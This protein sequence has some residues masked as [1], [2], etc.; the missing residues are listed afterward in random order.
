MTDTEK[1][2]LIE[3]YIKAYN[4]FDISGMLADLDDN[5]IFKNISKGEVTLELNGIDDFRKQAEQACG[6]FSE[7]E[8]KIQNIVFSEGGCRVDIA[9]R[10]KIAVDLPN[11]LKAGDEI[12]LKGK[13]VFHFAEGK[14][15]E[16]YDIS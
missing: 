12:K 15:S 10:A 14:I 3:Q 2:H 9:Y 11:G 5:I 6:F 16:I 13:S 7:R 8:Q 1:N 4:N